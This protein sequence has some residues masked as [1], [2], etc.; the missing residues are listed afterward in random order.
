MWF[1]LFFF[2]LTLATKCRSIYKNREKKKKTGTATMSF[3]AHHA[4]LVMCVCLSC[5]NSK[6]FSFSVCGIFSPLRSL[7]IFLLFFFFYLCV[8]EGYTL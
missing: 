7:S 1:L 5:L 4:S 2:F 3:Q 6:S 8:F